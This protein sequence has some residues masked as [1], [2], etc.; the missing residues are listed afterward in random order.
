MAPG[1]W[2]AARALSDKHLQ[3]NPWGVVEGVASP[4]LIM[5][6]VWE[7]HLLLRMHPGPA[8]DRCISK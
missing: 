3:G 2:E 4:L 5:R 7:E 8:R 1:S 6:W